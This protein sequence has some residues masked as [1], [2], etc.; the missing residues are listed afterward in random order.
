MSREERVHDTPPCFG[1]IRIDGSKC[2]IASTKAVV[3]PRLLR[4]T[5]SNA[6]YLGIR[7]II[8]EMNL[9]KESIN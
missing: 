7:A 9:L 4:K 6:I 2:R 1:Y 3:E 8:I 5:R